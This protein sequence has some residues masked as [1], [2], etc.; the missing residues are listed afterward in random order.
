MLFKVTIY[1]LAGVLFGFGLALSGMT[2]PKVVT[3]FLDL[4]GEWNL[5]L[6]F[7]MIGGIAITS[8]GYLFIFK[9]EQPIFEQQFFITQNKNIDKPLIIGATLFG[10]GWGLYG[11]CPGPAIA[12]LASLNFQTFIFVGAMAIGMLIADKTQSIFN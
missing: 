8:I 4:F 1:L 2:D 10:L 11:F 12:S 9:N 6:L 7:V 5:T 3:G